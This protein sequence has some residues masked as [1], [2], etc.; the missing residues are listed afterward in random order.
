MTNEKDNG[1]V[2]SKKVKTKRLGGIAAFSLLISL[3]DRLGEIIYDAFING[4]FGRIFTSHKK[5]RNKLSNGFFVT[6]VIRNSKIRKFFREIRRFLARNLESCVTVSLTNKIIDKLCSLPLQYYGNFGLFFGVYSIV[7]YYI[8]LFVPWLEVSPSSHLLIGIAITVASIPLMFSRINLATS[9]KNSVFGRGL[10][11]HTFGFSDESFDN[12]K[13]PAR[14][15]GNLMLLFGFLAGILTLVIHPLYI[16]IAIATVVLITL[17]ASAPEIG[18][19][20]TIVVIPFLT[21]TPMP[22]IFLAFLVLVT[23][24]FYI[25]KLIR[26]KRIFKLEAL[27]FT[28]LLFGILIMLSS[29]YS[30]GGTASV[31]SATITFVL[32]VGYFL[33]VNLMRTTAWIKRCIIA[34]ISSASIVSIIG[35]FEFVFGDKNNSWLDQ[36][37][38][39]TI[40]TRVVSLFENPNILAVF[41]VMIFPFLLA[42][43]IKSKEKNAKFLTRMLII[44]FL[45]CIVFTW[46]RAAWLAVILSI[47][48]FATLYTKKS[49]RIFGVALIIFPLIPIILPTSIIERFLSI[50]NLADSSIAYRI[51]TWKGTLAAIKD[52]LFCGIGY[53]DAAFQTVYPAYSYSGIE[54]APH[55][56]SLILQLL[57]SMGIIGVIVFCIAIFFSFQKSFE[58]IKNEKNTDASIYVIASVASIAS[59]LI[60]GIFDYIWYNPRIFYLFW[61]IIAIGNA[62]IRIGD[63]ESSRLEDFEHDRY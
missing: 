4:F 45:A 12:K 28:V 40:K 47:L 63:Y 57:L 52:Y 53:G 29:I 41:L 43:S 61:I 51:Y 39:N 48:I 10:L 50:S 58:Y 17:I 54:A 21:L 56:H 30:A 55:S 36:S 60:V 6:Y 16:I 49:F 11:K 34:L 8:R 2:T 24:F 33:L 1:K 31:A 25:I 20:L 13:T 23:A 62:I 15:K 3:F 44:L 37:F 46:S 32:L 35:V 9:V 5:L 18:V 7:I 26:G 42:L 19:L 22:T 38:Y 59:A 14:T 27:D